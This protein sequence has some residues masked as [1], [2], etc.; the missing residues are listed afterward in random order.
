MDI[1][2]SRSLALSTPIWSTYLG[3]LRMSLDP[4]RFGDR[5]PRFLPPASAL[6]PS[7]RHTVHPAQMEELRDGQH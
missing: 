7:E 2:S 3:A 6:L 1:E 4:Y 5:L